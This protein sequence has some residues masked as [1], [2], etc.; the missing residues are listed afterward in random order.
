[1]GQATS[2][3]ES[4]SVSERLRGELYGALDRIRVELDRIELL[5]VGL[6]AFAQPVPM[7]EPGFRHMRHMSASA[8]EVGNR[9]Y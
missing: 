6:G 1:M 2:L 4:D 8:F 5:S 3:K 7:Y 9:N